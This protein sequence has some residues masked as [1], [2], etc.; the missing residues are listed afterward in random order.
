MLERGSIWRRWDLHVHTPDTAMND[1]FGAWDEYL[2]AIE[3][4]SSVRVIGVTD[5]LLLSNYS[6]LRAIKSAGRL[7]NVDYLI[8]NLE[9]RLA[10]PTDKDTPV[11]I[12]ILVSPDDAGHEKH[13]NNALGRLHWEYYRQRY[14]CTADQL[15]SLGRAIEPS[16]S[17][18]RSALSK[19]VEQFKIDFS[20]FRD[21]YEKEPWLRQ[22]SLI[23]VSGNKDGLSGFLFEG[24]WAAMREEITRFSDILFSA[25]PGE[26]NFWLGMDKPEN[27]GFMRKL[28]GPKPCVHGSDAHALADLFKPQNDRF[29]WI[30]ADPNFDGLR[31]ILLE[32]AD[33]VHIGPTPPLYHDQARVIDSITLVDS[34]GWFDEVEIPLNPGLVSI[35]G[36]KGS[37]KSALAEVTSFAAGSWEPSEGSFIGRAGEYLGGTKV[38]LK[39]VDGTTTQI[40]LGGDAPDD[41]KVRFLSQRFVEKLCADDRLGEDLVREI[42]AVIFAALDPTDTLNASSFQELRHLRTETLVSEGELLHQEIG[43]LVREEIAHRTALAR[44][45][46]KIQLRDKLKLE[47]EGLN[48]QVPAPASDAEAKAQASLQTARTSLGEMQNTIA[49]NKQQ[50]QRLIDIRG[51]VQ[52]M[53]REIER[54]RGEL[55]PVLTAASIPAE[56]QVLFAPRFDEGWE[57]VLQRRDVELVAAIAVVEGDVENPKPGTVRHLA[58]QIARLSQLETADKARQERIKAIQT[59]VAAITVELGRL[60]AEI[61]QRDSLRAELN[62]ARARRLETYVAYF[63]NLAE[64]QKVLEALYQPVHDKL[65]DREHEQ[66]LKFSIRWEVD[67]GEWLERGGQ[68][69]DQ[70]RTIPYGTINELTAQARRVLVPAWSSGDA[71]RIGA[72]H[73]EFMKAFRGEL[74]P[75]AYLRSGV[76]LGELLE[77]LYDVGHIGLNY[78]LKYRGVDLEKLSPGTKGIVL[79][80]LYL[81][82]DEQDTRPLIVDQP[83]ENLDNESIFELL[84]AY[85]RSAKKRRQILLITHNPNLVVNGDSEQVI[86]ATV[87]LGA[88]GLPHMSYAASSLE[89]SKADGS[90][91]RQ[92]TCRI[93]EG[94]TEAFLRRERRYALLA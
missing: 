93:L 87:Q 8:P 88:S 89:N 46:E 30:K 36:Q 65:A 58:A 84:T 40:P 14:S 59:R 63:A 37:G 53:A 71:Q 27:V 90:G 85:F 43:R 15:R 33:R 19:G 23:A 81:G 44:I 94:G 22:N 45:P 76:T 72:A 79:L 69:M 48:K 60:D 7:Q 61:G 86:V 42:E 70:R 32:P 68:L 10:P 3:L 16:L 80:I 67:L 1:Q 62:A 29:C 20:S 18:D 21:W 55:A 78:G 17:D 54:F 13:I 31:Q 24:G 73:E 75:S 83:D 49:A 74:Q 92:R 5:Y 11:N 9:F 91:I 28:G 47:A 57:K 51:R 2:A 26:R 41:R 6:K 82:L 66:D 38:R 35:I 77:W 34:N 56:E 12:H 52:A 25:R 64:E 39:W 50:R 4:Q